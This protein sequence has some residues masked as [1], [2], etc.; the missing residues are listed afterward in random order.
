[1]NLLKKTCS[2]GLWNK[3]VDVQL[4]TKSK[5]V[6]AMVKYIAENCFDSIIWESRYIEKFHVAANNLYLTL[7]GL[8]ITKE[9]P[10]NP[11]DT[12]WETNEVKL[13][14]YNFEILES[15]YYD[16]SH[17]QKQIR[18]FD[19]DCTYSKLPLEQLISDFTIVTEDIKEKNDISIEQTF[20]G[21]PLNLGD[22]TW[23]YFKLRY[24]RME[25]LW[26]SFQEA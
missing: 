16:C 9:H 12:E 11:Y 8:V 25:M 23:G 26:D 21:F 3:D 18:D 6:K 1:M 22:D 14:F 13:V 20:E 10:L 24:N 7:E 17:V 5:G 4:N 15:G 19:A 2:A